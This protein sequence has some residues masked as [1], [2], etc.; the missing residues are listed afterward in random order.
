MHKQLKLSPHKALNGSHPRNIVMILIQKRRWVY[1]TEKPLW[2]NPKKRR[3]IVRV[4][5]KITSII[6]NNRAPC[7]TTVGRGQTWHGS[8]STWQRRTLDNGARG[9]HIPIPAKELARPQIKFLQQ[10]NY[11]NRFV[12]LWPC[13]NHNII[14][15]IFLHP[16]LQVE[17]HKNAGNRE[18]NPEVQV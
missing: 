18:M 12:H 8:R 11:Y 13:L 15:S 7:L 1:Y 5:G 16:H 10:H 14:E 4:D 3:V 2:M 9:V 6:L 17:G